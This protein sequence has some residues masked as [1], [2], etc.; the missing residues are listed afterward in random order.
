MAR[1]LEFKLTALFE[2]GQA[3]RDLRSFAG[4]AQKSMAR[5]LTPTGLGAGF[6]GIGG[7]GILGKA[8][9]GLA[10]YRPGG[11]GGVFAGITQSAASL[12]LAPV[13]ILSEFT[14]LIPGVG[15]ILGGVVGTAANI[16]QGLVGIAANVVGGIINAFGKLLQ[17]IV[18]IFERIV[19]A[20]TGV[21]GKLLKVALGVGAGIGALMFLGIRRNFQEAQMARLLEV[22]FGKPMAAAIWAEIERVH[23][24]GG[25]ISEL[26]DTVRRLGRAFEDPQKYLELMVDAAAGAG[27]SLQEVAD[28][29]IR[30]KT[31]EGGAGGGRVGFM[32][33][34]F[35]FTAQQIASIKTV[36]DLAGALQRR[37]A[38]LA[39]QMDRLDPLGNIWREIR[40]AQRDLTHDL[41]LGLLPALNRVHEG[42]NQLRDSPVFLNLKRQI[43]E[44]GTAI[45]QKLQGALQGM[46]DWLS[47][48]DWAAVWGNLLETP[49]RLAAQLGDIGALFLQKGPGGME[50]GP[51]VESVLNGVRWLVDQILI[52]LERLWGAIGQRAMTMVSDVMLS[53]SSVLGA[54]IPAIWEKWRVMPGGRVVMDTLYTMIDVFE[55]TGGSLREL[56][57]AAPNALKGVAQ[58]AESAKVNWEALRA[59]IAATQQALSGIGRGVMPEFPERP[60]A[61]AAAGGRAVEAE[62]APAAAAIRQMPAMQQAE[63]FL[64]QQAKQA[65]A[66]Q[67]AG[68]GE[69]AGLLAAAVK[70]VRED[71]A[72]AVQAILAD[73]KA[74]QE[75][76]DGLG[77]DLRDLRNKFRR[78]AAARA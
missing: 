15:G 24:F 77:R 42:M 48:R 36:E 58:H 74:T 43:G 22:Q 51:I 50:L 32:L 13:R 61:R 72:N 12:A 33:Q 23:E 14:R 18:S 26:F 34:R 37:Y 10:G 17:G 30:I 67:R 11:V 21:L 35:G 68:Y 52:V 65:A 20:V 19:G 62:R 40:L 69:K 38:G 27:A 70:Q 2:G 4:N 8:F 59:S 78:L 6:A 9:S 66:L 54:Q 25:E 49:K 16:L 46:W 1:E 29:L 55:K 71:L 76:L 64:V 39:Q 41:A 56:G 57:Y 47:T 75:E 53:I 31:G 63:R 3:L 45:V 5:A 28:L 7:G 44:V 73:K 60:G